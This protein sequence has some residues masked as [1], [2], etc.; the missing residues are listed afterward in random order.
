MEDVHI[1]KR[2]SK[3]MW[4]TPGRRWSMAEVQKLFPYPPIKTATHSKKKGKTLF[5]LDYLMHL[6]WIEENKSGIMR[7]VQVFV[8]E[9]G[10]MVKR[11][12]E[13]MVKTQRR[14]WRWRW[15]INNELGGQRRRA[16]K[17]HPIEEH[18]GATEQP[19]R[20]FASGARNPKRCGNERG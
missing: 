7:V 12:S 4:V 10:H 15:S 2:C 3:D 19:I 17:A 13:K 14:R 6:S 18:S 20:E 11:R 1:V 16:H 8:M 5:L 9:D